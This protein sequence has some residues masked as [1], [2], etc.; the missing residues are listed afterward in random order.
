MMSLGCCLENE[1]T[2]ML[3][4]RGIKGQRRT[5]PLLSLY[6]PAIQKPKYYKDKSCPNWEQREK[7]KDMQHSYFAKNIRHITKMR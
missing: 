4:K 1:T 7:E 3:E 6:L 2:T 5:M